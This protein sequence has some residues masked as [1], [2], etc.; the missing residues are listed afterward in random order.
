MVNL[1][2]DSNQKVKCQIFLAL[3]MEPTLFPK[4]AALEGDIAEHLTHE[5]VRAVRVVNS[6]WKK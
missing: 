4:A 5:L 2:S 6:F 3:P 1:Q